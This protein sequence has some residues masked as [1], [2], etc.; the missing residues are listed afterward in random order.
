MGQIL[1][2]LIVG[3]PIAVS[4]FTFMGVHALATMKPTDISEMGGGEGAPDSSPFGKLDPRGSLLERLDLFL[5]KKLNLEPK[6]DKLHMMLGRPK[7]MTP[8]WMLHV[9]EGAVVGTF[10]FL[11]FMAGLKPILVFSLV[12]FF[13]PDALMGSKVQK[14]QQEILG[15]FAQFVDL[16]ALLIESG[17]DYITAF[18]RIVKQARTRS[19]LEKEIEKTVSEIQLGTT[20]KNSLNHL[21][22]RTGL[23]E[24]R[25]FV[26][27]ITQSEELGT[28][29]VGLLREYAADMRFRRLNKAERLAAQASTK[30]LIPLFVFIFP[31]V[32]ILM[33][34]PLVKDLLSGGLGF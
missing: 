16:T 1:Q 3:L 33:L 4:I 15:N 27:L 17:S 21:A 34:S 9:K 23:Q 25:S 30:M 18:D 7:D 2:L 26:G 22:E 10:I 13:V 14:R 6:L 5:V 24:I 28:S 31:T 32:F 8:L 20:R 19:E 29:L 11:I 12:A